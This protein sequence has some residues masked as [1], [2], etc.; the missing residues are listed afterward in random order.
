MDE[1]PTISVAFITYNR[2]TTLRRTYDSFLENT[3][4][5]REKLQLIVAD[6]GS[7]EAAQAELRAMRFDTY[8]I[9]KERKGLGENQNRGLRAAKGDYLLQLQDDWL[10]LGPRDYLKDAI[11]LINKN[12]DVGMLILNPHPAGLLVE[13]VEKRAHLQMRIYQ[14]HPEKKI[15]KVG[16]HAYT[17]WPHLKRRQF[18]ESVGEY[19]VNVPMWECE[20]DYS[21]RVNA[22]SRYLIADLDRPAFHHIGEP[23]SF[24]TGNWRA[25]VYRKLK[26]YFKAIFASR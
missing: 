1:Y 21:R 24:N 4:W 7:D 15:N 26:P 14:N 18:W 16:E 10:C 17:D 20:L 3:N 8:V 22:Q 5:P 11:S 12:T 23:L 9:S 2:I 25:R 13:R 6:D 19:K